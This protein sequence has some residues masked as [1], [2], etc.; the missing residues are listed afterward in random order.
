MVSPLCARRLIDHSQWVRGTALLLLMLVTL[1]T[2]T[3]CRQAELAPDLLRQS[4]QTQLVLT[5]PTDPKTFNYALNQ[6]FP[7]VFLFTHQGL[8]VENGVTGQ[9]EPALA[10]SW[11]IS[12]DHK[13]IVF[14]LRNGLRWSDGHPLTA[15]DVVFTYQDIIFNPE[16][17]VES[18]DNLK[19]GVNGQFPQVRKL[20]ARRVE[21]LLP[22]PFA[23]FLQ[24][25]AGP[26][27]QVAILPKH[28]L[29]AAVRTKAADGNLKFN[30]FWSIDTPPEKL[31][32]NG[33][34]LIDRYVTGERVIFRRNPYYWQRDTQGQPLPYIDRIIWQIAESTDTQLL[35]FR[36]GELDVL[37]DVRPL[38]PEYFALL[39]REEQ[40]GQFRVYQGGPWSGTTFISFNLTQ[41]KDR[42][43]RPFVDPI[44]S[45]WFNT[46]AF[47]Q[48]IAY[49]IDRERINNN[50]FRGVSQLQ[51]SPISVQSPY[52]LKPEAGLQVYNYA[53]DQARALL[54]EAGFQ[55]NAAGQLLDGQGNRV[56][57][58]LLTNAGNKI[59]EA[60]GAQIKADLSQIGIQVNF[61]PIAFSTLVEKLSTSRDWECH[62]IGFTGGVE[63]H[64]SAN[65]WV[66][67]GGSHSFNLAPQPGQPPLQ[68][69]QPLPWELEIDRLFQAGAQELDPSKRQA[70]YA[71]F[72]A[73]VQEQ[74]PV[75]HLVNEMALM[76]VRDRVEGLRY[77]GL[78]SWGLW[79]I[80]ELKIRK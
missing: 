5:T 72:Q 34:Y 10:E 45:R 71:E 4:A 62:L 29:Q 14:T 11:A 23:P 8:T 74:L 30:S 47:R 77:S 22:E 17:P 49:A 33:P 41:A 73:L 56:Q 65:L 76:A 16:I 13:R 53:P 20:D 54:L 60:I 6:E 12:R 69:W 19:I 1:G 40:R 2:V 67:R 59:R 51:N 26:P 9:I 42:K 63:P 44:K 37:G 15:D 61:T 68:G 3:G 55:Y 52:Y 32:V 24:A 70:I 25:M 39:K 58:T 48:A 35:K 80:Q 66:S 18:R 64:S 43:G 78:P 57:F 38:R 31:V 7:S 75:I 27:D 21:F 50:I 36:S 28:A 79:N 46:V